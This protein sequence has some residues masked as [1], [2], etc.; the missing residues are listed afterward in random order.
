MKLS[1]ALTTSTTNTPP[2]TTGV[3]GHR[4]RAEITPTG[5]LVP[6]DGSDRLDWWIAADDRWHTPATEPSVRQ[7]RIRATPVTETRIRVPQGD[8]VQRIAT[9]ADEGGMTVIEIKNESP[10]AVAIAFS[11]GALLTERPISNVSVE[12]VEV[13][14][15]AVSLPLGHKATLRVAL[16]HDGRGAGPIPRGLPTV[17][18]TVAGWSS[19][20]DRAGRLVLPPNSDLPT[21]LRSH[22]CELA[23]GELADSDH[24]PADFLIGLEYLTRLGEPV[25]DWL[26]DVADAVGALGPVAGWTADMALLAAERIIRRATSEQRALTDIARIRAR[27]P[28]AERPGAAPAGPAT[29]TWFERGFVRDGVLM[30]DG[31]PS[32]WYGQSIEAHNLPTVAGSSVS[33]A[34]RWHGARP[35]VLW[36]QHGTPI[37]LTAPAA[38]PEWS[39]TA[40]TGESLWPAPEA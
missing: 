4:W 32:S 1:A 26:P 33:F 7:K 39:T 23:L 31:V 14:E 37:T 15:G 16:A 12:G 21:R 18:E 9:V 19:T 10:M 29:L 40:A 28:L 6:A 20:L 34:L 38:A 35:A 11:H 22:A 2:I 5:S 24:T 13:P 25:D 27:R 8:V 30:P 3:L 36:E 17:D